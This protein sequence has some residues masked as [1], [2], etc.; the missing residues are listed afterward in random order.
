MK[1]ILLALVFLLAA[2]QGVF[3]QSEM[4][5]VVYLKNGSI[6]KGIIVEQ[7]PNKSLKI[8]TP[9]GSLFFCD[10]N[11]VEKI[12]KEVPV[13]T[14]YRRT[15]SS[16]NQSMDNS[17]PT[18]KANGYKA[19]IDFGYTVG[20]G[21]HAI[22][23]AELTTSHGYQF[24]PYLFIGGGA[25]FQYYHEAEAFT[26]PIFADIRVNFTQGAIV[27]FA[28]IKAGYT[29]NLT[30]G[31]YGIGAYLAPSVGVKFVLPDRKAVNLSLGYTAQFE[32]VSYNYNYGNGNGN[33]YGYYHNSNE[34]LGGVTIRLGIEF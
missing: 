11:E 14:S 7:V 18:I 21:D 27:P 23:R 6:I 13:R 25:G 31:L 2:T 5:E 28:G 16:D 34:N 33:G 9:D 19:F 24:N 4:Q 15:A 12:T 8:Q 20:T 26:L 32:K 22:G 3:S 10:L 30:D 1:R 29:L 17:E